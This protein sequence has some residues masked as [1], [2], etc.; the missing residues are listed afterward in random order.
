MR[1][2]PF[3]GM[4]YTVDRWKCLFSMTPDHFTTAVFFYRFVFKWEALLMLKSPFGENYLSHGGLVEYMA[5]NVLELVRRKVATKL[6]T[7]WDQVKASRNIKNRLNP[8]EPGWTLWEQTKKH[9]N[10]TKPG[11]VVYLLISLLWTKNYDEPFLTLLIK[12]YFM[13][14]WY[15]FSLKFIFPSAS[16]LRF[17]CN[18]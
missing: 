15:S 3:S 10:W 12:F 2:N 18:L 8:A 11:C 14:R 13:G 4:F 1:E 17:Y 6:E 7:K 16:V 9:Q 5:M